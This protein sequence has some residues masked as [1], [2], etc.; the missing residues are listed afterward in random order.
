MRADG[1][2]CSHYCEWPTDPHLDLQP[3]A[4]LEE[5]SPP[6]KMRGMLQVYMECRWDNYPYAP[7]RRVYWVCDVHL[8]AVIK[9]INSNILED[10]MAARYYWKASS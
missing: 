10:V 1:C 8:A 7:T 2:L 4:M 9:L 6:E 5:Q 3:V